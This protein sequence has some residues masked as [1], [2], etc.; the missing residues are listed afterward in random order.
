MTVYDM[1]TVQLVPKVGGGRKQSELVTTCLSLGVDQGIRLSEAQYNEGKGVASVYNAG[2]RH[3]IK[4]R[5]RRDVKGNIWLF[6]MRTN[7]V[8]RK[9][10]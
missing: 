10:A 2:H 6:R 5:V 3:G 8:E 4:F 9:A 7:G 1:R